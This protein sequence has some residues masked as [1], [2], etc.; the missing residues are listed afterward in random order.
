MDAANVH[1]LLDWLQSECADRALSL[2]LTKPDAERIAAARKDV[3]WF[4]RRLVCEL[5]ALEDDHRGLALLCLWRA[6]AAAAE[7]GHLAGR[8]D[9]AT[10]FVN[11]E[12]TA[13]GRSASA[14]RPQEQERKRILRLAIGPEVGTV[15][16]LKVV[17]RRVNPRITIYGQDEIVEKTLG[18]WL[19]R[20]AVECGVPRSKKKKRTP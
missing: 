6:L 12:N 18:R 1:K 19:D 15:D 10:E 20:L 8:S 2:N 13:R 14:D 16:P 9:S 4:G 7:I 3:A 17:L 5:A 11:R